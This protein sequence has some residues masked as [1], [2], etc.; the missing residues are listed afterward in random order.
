M[1]IAAFDQLNNERKKEL[2]LTCCGSQQWVNNMV[3]LLPYEDLVDVMEDAEQVWYGLDEPEWLHAFSHHPKIG[4]LSSHQEKFASTAHL[5]SAEQASMATATDA[6]MHE[7][8]ELN[9]RYESKFGFIFI[10]CA[11]GRSPKE[12][13]QSINQRLAN[14]RDTEL[15]NAVNEQN[16]IIKLRLQ[17]LFV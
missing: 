12:M 10:I 9:Q 2:L 5:A 1:T 7:L 4:D 8:A 16:E 14:D 13:L 15:E 17:K 11:T 6:T 3:E